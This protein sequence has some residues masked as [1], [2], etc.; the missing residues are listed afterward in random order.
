MLKRTG[1]T[2]LAATVLVD[3]IG[4]GIVLPLLPFY[5]EELGATPLEVTLIIASFSAMQLLAAP[6]WGRISDRHGR[7]PLILAG[8]FASAISYLIFALADTLAVLLLSRIA[9]GAA[10]GTISV[11]Q[12]YVADST[13]GNERTHGLGL[14]GAASGLGI[15]LGP[16]IGGFFSRFGLGAPG[17]V[18]AALCAVNG[19]AAFMY[20]PESRHFRERSTRETG[21]RGETASLRGWVTA[22]TRFP[23]WLLFAVYFLGISS[24]A[25][26][27]SVL[28]L[29]L[30]RAFEMGASEM[31]LIFTTAGA[32]TVVVRGAAVGRLVRRVGEAATVRGGAVILAVGISAIPLIPNRWWLALLVPMWAVATGIMFPSL[33]SL[34][35]QAT[36]RYSQGSVLGGSQLFGGLGRVLG[37]VWAGLLFQ[38]VSIASPF[39][40]A[41]ILVGIA[42]VLATR[43]PSPRELDED[44]NPGSGWSGT[45]AGPE[46]TDAAEGAGP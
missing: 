23:L 41:G 44:A 38:Q 26:M 22:L 1:L 20:L 39:A 7:R 40:L 3:M 27:T 46:R 33:A 28:A 17:F 30:E 32:V 37:P 13:E 2:V 9:A 21:M 31:G 42:A 43:I 19:L 10:G 4:F 11:A 36:D 5:A 12:A 45:V 8:L 14:I 18:A 29:Y 24:F 15:M 6:V 34:I 35:S 16:A 25:A